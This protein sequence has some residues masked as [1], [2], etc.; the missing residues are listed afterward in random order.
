MRKIITY[1]VITALLAVFM[2]VPVI[3]A[4]SNNNEFIDFNDYAEYNFAEDNSAVTVDVSFPSEWN[5]T[6]IDFPDAV[7]GDNW[8]WGNEIYIEVQQIHG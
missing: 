7:L 8:Y 6:F 3:A 4:D 1:L 2:V 5:I